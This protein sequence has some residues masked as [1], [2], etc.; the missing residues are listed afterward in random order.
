MIK[1]YSFALSGHSHRVDLMLN[2]LGLPHENITID[3]MKGEQKTP[4]FLALNPFGTV[5]ALEDDGVVLGDSNAII[6]YLAK[7]Y[8]GGKWL[9]EDPAQ[10]AEVQGWLTVAASKIA[11]GPAS[12]RLVTVFGASLDHEATKATANALFAVMDKALS[13]RRFLIGDQATIADVAGYSYIAHA[14]EGGVSLDPYPNIRAW[15]GNIE[16]LDGFV[17]MPATK[18][19]LVT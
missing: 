4:E 11:T 10:A 1:F 7:K 9:P 19:G 16:A 17:P 5:P 3:L 8:G 6:L 2:L 18:A 12:A 15:L 13:D 14:P